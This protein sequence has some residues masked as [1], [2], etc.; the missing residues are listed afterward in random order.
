MASTSN[1]FDA[2]Y[3]EPWQVLGVNLKPFSLGHYIKLYRLGC[4]YV[5]DETKQ[6]TL[7]DLVLGVAVC[8]MG[9]HQDPAK[10]PFWIWLNREEPGGWRKWFYRLCK[11]LGKKV[12]SPAELDMALF[13]RAVGMFDFADKARLFADYIDAHS[14]APAYWET[15]KQDGGGNGGHWSQSVLHVL[16]SKCG[17]TQE[18]AHN[19]PLS[20]ALADFFKHAES[21]GAVRIMTEQERTALGL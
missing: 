1:Y 2:A 4:A 19:V 11:K 9:S 12:P 5:A 18:E 21:E 14:K 13:G 20:K 8:S 16:V 10:D 17:Y 6:P 15:G 3:P 7:G